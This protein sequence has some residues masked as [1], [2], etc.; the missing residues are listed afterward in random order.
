[1]LELSTKKVVQVELHKSEQLCTA[2]TF[3]DENAFAFTKDRICRRVTFPQIVM[4]LREQKQVLWNMEKNCLGTKKVDSNDSPFH[5][6]V[7]EEA[8]G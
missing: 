8:T 4:I 6:P 2:A 5:A 3:K 1:M 7:T